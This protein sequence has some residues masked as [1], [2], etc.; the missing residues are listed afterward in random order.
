MTKT[1]LKLI[2]ITLFFSMT[3]YGLSEADDR[4]RNQ[5]LNTQSATV[6]ESG[7]VE[8]DLSYL[9]I[10]QIGTKSGAFNNSFGTT[11]QSRG[12][13]RYHQAM[14]AVTYGLMDTMDIARCLVK[15]INSC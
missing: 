14:L 8:I 1:L 9:H 13:M 5:K 2:V 10:D 6:V 3:H 12:K 7:R 11:G 15:V 4:V